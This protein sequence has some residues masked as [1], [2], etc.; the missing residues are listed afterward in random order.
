MLAFGK[1][2]PQVFPNPDGSDWATTQ[3]RAAGGCWL[4][5]GISIQTGQPTMR[6]WGGVPYVRV[7]TPFAGRSW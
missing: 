7:H 1:Q 2:I 3:E 6:R 5:A 4:Y